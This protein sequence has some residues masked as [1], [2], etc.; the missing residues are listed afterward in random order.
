[1]TTTGADRSDG[2]QDHSDQGEAMVQEPGR[3]W[4][5]KSDEKNKYTEFKGGTE[6]S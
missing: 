4:Q 3:S 1:M 5:W 2:A 6:T